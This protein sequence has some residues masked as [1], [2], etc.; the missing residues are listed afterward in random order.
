MLSLCLRRSGLGRV[1]ASCLVVPTLAV[2]AVNDFYVQCF[3]VDV[4]GN[5]GSEPNTLS[6]EASW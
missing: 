4:C 3:E 5:G 2:I 6:L 1:M